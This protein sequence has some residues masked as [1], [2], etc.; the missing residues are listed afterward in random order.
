MS[1]QTDLASCLLTPIKFAFGIAGR[2][3]RTSALCNS[4]LMPH[5]QTFLRTRWRSW[6]ARNNEQITEVVSRDRTGSPRGVRDRLCGLPATIFPIL[7]VCLFVLV[8]HRSG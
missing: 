1:L 3:L 4:A 7:S 8:E 5:R 6:K 2:L